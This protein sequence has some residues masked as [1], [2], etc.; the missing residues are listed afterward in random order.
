MI[1]DPQMLGNAPG[2]IWHKLRAY[3]LKLDD[4]HVKMAVRCRIQFCVLCIYLFTVQRGFI[5]LRVIHLY[6]SL[7]LQHQE[8]QTRHEAAANLKNK[9]NGYR[10]YPPA[11]RLMA[12]Q[13]RATRKDAIEVLM[14]DIARPA[15]ASVVPIVC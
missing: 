9:G 7:Y 11:E 15:K 8:D 1:D 13:S 4:L 14:K 12:K 5:R 3:R 6:A 10:D 2:A